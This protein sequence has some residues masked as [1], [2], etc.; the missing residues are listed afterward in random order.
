LVQLENEDEAKIL[1]EKA[2]TCIP[3]SVTLWLALAKLEDYKNAR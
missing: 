3:Q 2:V 1:L